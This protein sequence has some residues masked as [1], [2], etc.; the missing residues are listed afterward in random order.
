M[1]K[2]SIIHH[3][4]IFVFLLHSTTQLFSQNKNGKKNLVYVDNQ[5]VMRWTKDKKEA[6]FFGVNYTLPY[7]VAKPGVFS[8]LSGYP[9]PQNAIGVKMILIF[10]CFNLNKR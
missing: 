10:R 7:F 4:L 9:F 1:L 5:G 6:T 2:T 8:S 3:L